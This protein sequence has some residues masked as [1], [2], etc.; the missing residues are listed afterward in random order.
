MKHLIVLLCLL[1][2]CVGKPKLPASFDWRNKDGVNYASPTRNQHIPQYCGSS[3]AFGTT[4]ALADRINIMRK[5]QWP[6][7][8]LSVQNVLDCG[9]AGTCHGGGQIPV[10]QYAFK[11]GIPDESCNSYQAKDQQC[12]T[13]NQCGKCSNYGNCQ[14]VQEHDRFKVSRFG[15][16]KGRDKMMAEIYN[17]GPISCTIQTT[18]KFDKYTGGIYKEHLQTSDGNHVISIA[19]WGVENGVEYWIGRNSWGEPWGEK[20][21]FKIVTSSYRGGQGNEYNLGV[22]ENCAFGVPILP[23]SWEV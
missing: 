1:H 21:W 18:P 22:E 2:T 16:V 10:Y 12:T 15:N 11:D 7:A 19:G 23:K 6:T 3:W 20:G 5:G 4:S 13:F 9:N 17:G 8:V 14:S